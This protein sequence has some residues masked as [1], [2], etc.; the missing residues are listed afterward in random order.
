[1]TIEVMV[2]KILNNES[3]ILRLQNQFDSKFEQ[4]RLSAENDHKQTGFRID[5]LTQK[6]N[7]A[8][9]TTSNYIISGQKWLL[10]IAIG[11]I[12]QTFLICAAM[13]MRGSH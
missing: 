2:E 9:L 7:D 5:S 6:V 13:Y 10:G 8:I 4:A 11:I 1:M 3:A 12:V